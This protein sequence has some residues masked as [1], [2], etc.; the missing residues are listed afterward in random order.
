MWGDYRRDVLATF[1]RH[2]RRL[3]GFKDKDIPSALNR[4]EREGFIEGDRLGDDAGFLLTAAGRVMAR[5]VGT[6]EHSTV[7][8]PPGYL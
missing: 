4:L 8:A 3:G 5:V 1:E 2:D 6:T 7:S